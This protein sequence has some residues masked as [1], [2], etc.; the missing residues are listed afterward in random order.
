[1]ENER[2]VWL[3]CMREKATGGPYKGNPKHFVFGLGSYG[4]GKQRSVMI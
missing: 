3:E 2:P 1:M 4:V